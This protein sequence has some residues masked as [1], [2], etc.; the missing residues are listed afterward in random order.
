ME[1]TGA[2]TPD[3]ASRAFPTE[4]ELSGLR[5]FPFAKA[6]AMQETTVNAKRLR[7]QRRDVIILL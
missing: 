7:F 6:S 1:R 4:G 3:P 2:G 5:K